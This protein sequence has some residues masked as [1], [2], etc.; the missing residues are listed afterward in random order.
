MPDIRWSDEQLESIRSL[1]VNVVQL[2]IAWGRKPADEVSNL[3]D[4]DVGQREKLA[5][6]SK[7]AKKHAAW[8][9]YPFSYP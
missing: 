4:L 6:R 5:F 2:S 8:P 9:R 1:G 3:E 7:L